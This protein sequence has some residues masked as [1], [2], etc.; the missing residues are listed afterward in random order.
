MD[1]LN[2]QKHG[3]TFNS[4]IFLRIRLQIVICGKKTLDDFLTPQ[5][6]FESKRKEMRKKHL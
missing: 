6:H 1:E 5:H 3:S 2:R 4:P